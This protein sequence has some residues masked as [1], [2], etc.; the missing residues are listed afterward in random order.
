MAHSFQ[1]L[2]SSY[3]LPSGFHWAP[4]ALLR[5]SC[6]TPCRCVLK[7][8]PWSLARLPPPAQ[9]TCKHQ[10]ILLVPLA[11]AQAAAGGSPWF[12][13]MPCPAVNAQSVTLQNTD[14]AGVPLGKA[15]VCRAGQGW[16]ES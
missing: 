7:N 15:Q 16:D 5:A 10:E 14:A 4:E 6:Q 8:T 13:A 2:T 11:W 1:G 12:A 9:H 3:Y